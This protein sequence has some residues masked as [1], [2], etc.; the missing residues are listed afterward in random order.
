MNFWTFLAFVLFGIA[1]IGCGE[2]AYTDNEL[3]ETKAKLNKQKNWKR[4]YKASKQQYERKIAE[5]EVEIEALRW[6]C[7][8][9]E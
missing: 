2:H 5:M 7:D 8:I 4:I 1:C 9:E 6:T 3:E